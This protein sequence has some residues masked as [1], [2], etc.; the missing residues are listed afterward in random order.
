MQKMRWR[1]AHQRASVRRRCELPPAG[2]PVFQ[3]AA[4][5]RAQRDE[6]GAPLRVD[7][8]HRVPQGSRA[9]RGAC[10]GAHALGCDW[11]CAHASV[12]DEKSRHERE[13]CDGGLSPKTL[14]FSFVGVRSN[15]F[16]SGAPRP[17]QSRLCCKCAAHAI[18]ALVGN[19]NL[20][21]RMAARPPRSW[22]PGSPAC[23]TTCTTPSAACA[24]ARCLT[25][26]WTTQTARRRSRTWLSACGTQ[27]WPE[28][29]CSLR[30]FGAPLCML[31]PACLLTH[32][33]ACPEP[34]ARLPPSSP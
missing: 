30:P 34:A 33:L 7:A 11:L 31:L 28:G 18:F 1:A 29:A 17:W 6:E 20:H 22:L 3:H 9:A 26:C 4:R 13:S 32:L 2:L 5:V 19:Q 24:L 16:L 14:L 12:C 15:S 25:C 23:G 10:A 27:T 8:G 21:S